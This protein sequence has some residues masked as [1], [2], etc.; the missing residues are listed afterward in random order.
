[1]RGILAV[2][3]V[4]AGFFSLLTDSYCLHRLFRRFPSFGR[5]PSPDLPSSFRVPFKYILPGGRR[6][7]ARTE[8]AREPGRERQ[9]RCRARQTDRA[10]AATVAAGIAQ[11]IGAVGGLS[12][13]QV[14]DE[15]NAKC[16]LLKLRGDGRL[17]KA[18]NE[19]VNCRRAVL[20]IAVQ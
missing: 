9:R 1:M 5:G 6:R 10:S 2:R 19:S 11:G 16:L 7:H 20:K 14:V 13:V 4:L 15:M 3:R 8:R 18:A 17:Q 12:H